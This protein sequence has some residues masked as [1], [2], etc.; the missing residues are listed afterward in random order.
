M[1][2]SDLLLAG[3]YPDP[4]VVRVGD[5]YWLVTST[6]EY[7]PG[8]PVFTS[9]DLRT[10]HQ[11]GHVVDRP[12]QLDLSTVPSSGGLF[13]PTIRHHDGRWFVACTLVH[14][15]GR[16]GHVVLTAD[17]PRGPWSDP[18]WVGDLPGIDP[19]LLFDGDRIWFCATTPAASPE[20]PG[21]T[22]V[23][24]CELDATTLQPLT[25]PRTIWSGALRGAVW[26]EG[27]HLYAKDGWYYLLA[28]EGGT[29]FFHALCVARSR[30]VTGP[31]EPYP[32]NPV[33]THRHLGRDHPV[34]DVGHADLVE[35]DDGWRAV[36][37]ATRPVDG[38]ALLGR[39]TFG[40]E[41]RWEDDWPVLAPGRG[42]VGGGDAPPSRGMPGTLEWTQVRTARHGFARI[43][44]AAATVE[45]QG[46]PRLP[47]AGTP[48]FVGVRRRHRTVRFAARVPADG[49]AGLVVR[50]SDDVFALCEVHAGRVT[51]TLH[52]ADGAHPLGDVAVDGPV[53]VAV[54]A[55]DLAHAFEIG[56]PSP[57]RIAFDGRALSPESTGGFVGT[58]LGLVA[59]GERSTTLTHVTYEG[60]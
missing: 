49:H 44:P 18:V 37:L 11:T 20:W 40:V 47:A 33:L 1:T 12:G 43:D 3:T 16:Q 5:A 32:G 22:T 15:T 27:P 19:S 52:D 9:T 56:G 28:S 46:G 42:R 38:H 10:W 25:A 31:Y 39:E 23:Y 59:F 58:W 35:T 55:D 57:A 54:V 60:A 8:L 34:Q 6:F 26:A 21:Q 13:A 14:G 36:L 24:V 17:D 29:E 2:D 30:E 48:S 53:D 50:Q 4:S 45:L 51:A 41:V 7:F